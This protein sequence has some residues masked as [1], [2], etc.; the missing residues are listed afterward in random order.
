M[1]ETVPYN[2][3]AYVSAEVLRRMHIVT[4][5]NNIIGS[6]PMTRE[7]KESSAIGHQMGMADP[8]SSRSFSKLP[9]PLPML[10][11]LSSPSTP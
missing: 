11:D 4:K 2:E 6:P 7:K 8:A 9:C 5:N 1:M 3:S 10:R